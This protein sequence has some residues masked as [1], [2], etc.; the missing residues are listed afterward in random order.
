MPPEKSPARISLSLLFWVWLQI[1]AQAFGG[2]ATLLL[3]LRREIVDKRHWLTADELATA[4]SLCSVTPGIN[5]IAIAALIGH[6]VRSLAGALASVLGL[7]SVGAVAT[8]VLTLGYRNLQNLAG[9]HIEAALRGI[10]PATVGVGL[11]TCWQLLR[12]QL[13]PK[14]KAPDTKTPHPVPLRVGQVQALVLCA[15]AAL[16]LS[17]TRLPVVLILLAAGSI[18]VTVAWL[19]ARPTSEPKKET[20]L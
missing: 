11:L 14:D 4:W 2:G 7:L 12:P 5:Q 10:V 15:A 3:L 13:V 20:S 8:L 19:T 9:G 1:G 18:G 16:T 6:R 17:A